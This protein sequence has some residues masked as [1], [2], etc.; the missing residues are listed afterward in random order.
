MGDVNA[1]DRIINVF[2]NNVTVYWQPTLT[3]PG[4]AGSCRRERGLHSDPLHHPCLAPEP[5]DRPLEE[6]PFLLTYALFSTGTA[7]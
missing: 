5:R 2:S 4:T 7:L 1:S 3:G 6:L